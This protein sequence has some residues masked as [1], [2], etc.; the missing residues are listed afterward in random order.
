MYPCRELVVNV[1]MLEW[2]YPLRELILMYSSVG[3]VVKGI[4][5]LGA[6][7]KRYIPF[8]SCRKM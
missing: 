1:N 7:E 8:G 4:S 3:A 5:L 2:V 6:V